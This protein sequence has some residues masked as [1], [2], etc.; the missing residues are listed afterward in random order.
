MAFYHILQRCQQIR[1]DYV[2]HE[3]RM[4]GDD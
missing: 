4:I 3:C 2:T 1:L